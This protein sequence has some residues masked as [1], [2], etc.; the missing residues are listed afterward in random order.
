[1]AGVIA[2]LLGQF[3]NGWL[4]EIWPRSVDEFPRYVPPVSE[5]ILKGL[6]L[7]YLIRRKR[8]GFMVDAAIFGFAIGAGFAIVENLYYLYFLSDSSLFIWVL[9][10]FGTAVMHGCATAIFG[11]ISVSR[12]EGRGGP[13]WFHF[14]PGLALAIAI[15]S[16]FNHFFFSPVL[17][18]LGVVVGLPL[19]MVIVYQRSEIALR[20]W[21][22]IGFDTDAEMMEIINTGKVTE[23][24]FGRYLVSLKDR[25]PPEAVVDMFC[26]LR[27]QVELSVQAK[28][29][30]MM[31]EAGYEVPPDPAIQEKL[32]ELTYLKRSIGPT[33]ELAL[34]P[35]LSQRRKDRWQQQLLQS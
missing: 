33:G 29:L 25:F 34:A 12:V 11:L 13:G 35:F 21:L 27:I 23:T 14:L 2:A 15:H 5:E 1:L 16:V 10:G 24:A 20:N 31:R 8:I 9:R 7:I 4:I 6:F 19:V 3:V 22:G 17:T 30:L 26:Y 18:V 28:G 32:A